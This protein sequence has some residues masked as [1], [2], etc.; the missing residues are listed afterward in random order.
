MTLDA[1]HSLNKSFN[2]TF[3]L[4]AAMTPVLIYFYFLQWK[5]GTMYG[6]DLYIFKNHE[7]LSNFSEKISMPVSFG[8][9]RPVHGLSMHFLIEIFQKHINGYYA[10]NIGIQA[11]NTFLFALVINLFVRSFYLSLLF[12]LTVGLSRFA[13]FNI[14]QLLNGGALEG[15]AMTFFLASLFFFVRTLIRN[16]Y[17]PKR[18]QREI[19]L[20]VLFANLSI[21]THERYIVLLPFIILL[22]FLYPG[23][24][25]LTAKQKISIIILVLGSIV[26]NVVLKKAVY[27]MPFF[28]GT[29]GTNIS[30]SF[31]S[32]MS[33]F[34]EAVLSVFQI[35]TGP[36]YLVGIQFADL[37]FFDK[38]LASTLVTCVLAVLVIYF[39]NTKK[40]FV[41]KNK[42]RINHFWLLISLMVLLGLFLV[43]AVVTVRLEQRWLQASYAIFVLIVIAACTSFQFSNNTTRNLLLPF[44]LILLLWVD[45][46]YLKKGANN[47][48]IAYAQKSASEFERAVTDGTIR[49]GTK[50]IYIWEKQRDA[51]SES[52]ISWILGEGYFFD[53]YQSQSKKVFYIDS[54]Y[55]GKTTFPDTALAG[56]NKYTDQV[57]NSDNG[58]TDIT[59]DYLQGSP[60]YF[61]RSRK[62]VAGDSSQYFLK[63]F[64]ISAANLNR[65]SIT[66]F[67]DN[68]NGIRWTNGNAA[69]RLVKNN[70]IKDTLTL[71]LNI[72]RPSVSKNIIPKIVLQAINDSSHA[73]F[74]SLREGNKYTF[75]FCFSELTA[76][77]KINILSDTIPPSPPDQR[78][79]SF[80]FVSLEIRK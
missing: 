34:M 72:Y 28:V 2:Y 74:F 75:K 73:P 68:E 14:T 10:F 48:Y 47:I 30:F 58:I 29:G 24:Q 33:F 80:P 63:Q 43:P 66:G 35:N 23:L 9:Y 56:F 55:P 27:G 17:P 38:F 62:I 21:Y 41:L 15:L 19:I 32:A 1:R 51:N 37:P 22:V 18:Q 67:Y 71:I 50:N 60:D 64:L 26:L 40:A 59:S 20:G 79:L 46:N 11:L 3:V 42:V 5:T 61:R 16:D 4:F 36:S 31:S 77:Q 69:I 49:P 70:I 52:T 76:I 57:I 44:F 7:A 78:I 25:K 53:F 6:D 45:F 13:Y 12:G 54:K 8:K 39:R 65:F